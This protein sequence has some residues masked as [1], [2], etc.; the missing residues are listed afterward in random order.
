LFSENVLGKTLVS[1]LIFINGLEVKQ[2][3]LSAMFVILTG[4]LEILPFMVTT[5]PTYL[6]VEFA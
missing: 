4:P 6:K 3:R 1:T 2:N 5:S